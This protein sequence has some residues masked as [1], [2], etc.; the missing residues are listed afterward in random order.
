MSDTKRSV[1]VGWGPGNPA[2]DKWNAS[3]PPKEQT[4]TVKH[5]TRDR[6]Q[7]ESSASKKWRFAKGVRNTRQ[8]SRNPAGTG[9]ARP[10]SGSEVSDGKLTCILS[11]LDLEFFSLGPVGNK[12]FVGTNRGLYRLDVEILD[13][14]DRAQGAKL[15]RDP[16]SPV[17]AAVGPLQPTTVP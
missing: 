12:L 14:L 2:F 6:D 16:R 4:K 3:R 13:Q 10:G 5:Q 11:E 7:G 17:P 8:R 9:V 1:Q 15:E